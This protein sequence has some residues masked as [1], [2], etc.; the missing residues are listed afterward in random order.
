MHWP[1]STPRLV[2]ARLRQNRA[3]QLRAAGFSY[4]AI[5]RELGFGSRAS[6]YKSVKRALDAT[7]AEAALAQRIMSR[8]RLE[9]SLENFAAAVES[10]NF[11]KAFRMIQ[12]ALAMDRRC[13]GR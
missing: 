2:R 12:F 10:G 8:F 4:A 13:G 5:A 3:L 11:T 6:A 7:R 9:R 1:V